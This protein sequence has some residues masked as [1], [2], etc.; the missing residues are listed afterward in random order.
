MGGKSPGV[1]Q[2]RRRGGSGEPS[3]GRRT[4]IRE[5]HEITI[6]LAVAEGALPIAVM[7]R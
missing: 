3:C 4:G 6:E 5:F 2:R 1:V 7:Q